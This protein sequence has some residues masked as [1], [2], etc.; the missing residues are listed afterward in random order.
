MSGDAGDE[1]GDGDVGGT[2]VCEAW[3]LILL[4]S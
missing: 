1:S 3:R 4:S 2:A